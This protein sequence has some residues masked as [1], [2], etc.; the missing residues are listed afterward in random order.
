[1][2][3]FDTSHFRFITL[4][5]G[6]A[7]AEV[8]RQFGRLFSQGRIH[9]QGENVFYALP[10]A[11][12]LALAGTI[13]ITSWVDWT[14]AIRASGSGIKIERCFSMGMLVLVIDVVIVACYFAMA[15]GAKIHDVAPKSSDASALN[16]TGS[17][18][19]IFGLYCIWFVAFDGFKTD[20]MGPS[21]LCFLLSLL[22]ALVYR[23]R[24]KGPLSDYAR[25]RAVVFTDFALLALVLMYRAIMEFE[26]GIAASSFL[27]GV[28]AAIAAFGWKTKKDDAPRGDKPA[29][30]GGGSSTG[31]ESEPPPQI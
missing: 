7:I 11:T 16:E 27:I 14:H 25:I 5:F 3:A 4:L 15:H 30:W 23:A 29:D 13:I 9:T 31:R 22:I 28:L 17:V 1:M 26:Y 19:A 6:L 12:H 2:G 10:A 20:Q 21:I 24:M 18:A 8:A